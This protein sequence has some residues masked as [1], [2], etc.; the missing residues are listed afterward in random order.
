MK[1]YLAIPFQQFWNNSAQT[2]FLRFSPAVDLKKKKQKN[3]SL[4]QVCGL[5]QGGDLIQERKKKE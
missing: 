1:H 5:N 3:L 4:N 2:I